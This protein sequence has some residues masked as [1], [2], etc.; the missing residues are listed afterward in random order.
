MAPPNG[1]TAGPP[2]GLLG[3]LVK[4]GFAVTIPES[5]NRPWLVMWAVATP[6]V[7]V[8]AFHIA[9]WGWVAMAFVGFGVPEWISIQKQKDELPP[10][11][12][13]IRHFVPNWVAFPAIYFCLGSIGAN[14]LTAPQPFHVGLLVGLLGWLTDHFTVTYARPGETLYSE[15]PPDP[16]AP[17]QPSPA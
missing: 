7:I 6:L 9:F 15:P 17:P 4:L 8:S 1:G 16:P 3:I 2:G 11:T 10:L 5:W 14:W 13:T 12:S